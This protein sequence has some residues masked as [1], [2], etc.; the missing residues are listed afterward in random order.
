LKLS[1]LILTHNRPELFKRCIESV[2]VGKPDNVEILVNNDSDD[3]VEIPGAT[4]YYNKAHDI[5][6][7]YESLFDKAIGE[8]IWFLEDDDYAVKN[9]YDLILVNDNTLFKY[10]P[11]TGPLDY[12][13]FWK[14][15]TF[16]YNF[17]LSQM[18]FKKSLLTEFP[19]SNNLQNDLE[20]F[21]QVNNKEPFKTI[22]TPIFYQTTD[23]KDNISF[24]QFNKDERFII[25]ERYR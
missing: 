24:Y 22:N 16:D 8:F 14:S 3:I 5:S 15:N 18:V 1:I 19:T 2:L 21:Y 12:F 23:G 11:F 4:Y 25:D 17:Q 10:I 6:E 9:L 20:I 13:R 7:L